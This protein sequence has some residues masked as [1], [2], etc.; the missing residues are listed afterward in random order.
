MLISTAMGALQVK[1]VPPEMHDELRRRA[2]AAGLT[3]ADFVLDVLRRE[4]ALPTMDEWFAEL[5]QLDPGLAAPGEVVS[6]LRAQ[7]RARDAELR[8]AVR[9]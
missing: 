3:L 4:L 6:E 9:S 8:H 2:A 1:N 5:D 7:R